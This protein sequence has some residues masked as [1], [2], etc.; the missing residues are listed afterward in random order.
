MNQ[1]IAKRYLA[2]MGVTPQSVDCEALYDA[3]LR[4]DGLDDLMSE[5][6]FQKMRRLGYRLPSPWPPLNHRD[7]QVQEGVLLLLGAQNTQY[8]EKIQQEVQEILAEQALTL[9][10]SAD[11]NAEEMLVLIAHENAAEFNELLELV[12]TTDPSDLSQDEELENNYA[13][14]VQS[15]TQAALGADLIRQSNVR[16]RMNETQSHPAY[17]ALLPELAMAMKERG[18]KTRGI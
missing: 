5:L 18:M 10:G 13:Y 2:A 11:L 8:E 9:K 3:M 7:A 14:L 1:K 16:I 15:A 4:Y 17:I 12:A 6:A